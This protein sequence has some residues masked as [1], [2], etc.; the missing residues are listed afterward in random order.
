MPRRPALWTAIGLV[1]LG[2]A[3][4][5][6]AFSAVY[7]HGWQQLH[8]QAQRRLDFLGAD[9]TTTLEKYEN[10]PI[11]LASHSELP[12]LLQHRRTRPGETPSTAGWSAWPRPPTSSPST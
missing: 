2:A 10:L 11:A 12:D 8:D 1:L 5:L 6:G 7:R 3:I 9:L 4:V